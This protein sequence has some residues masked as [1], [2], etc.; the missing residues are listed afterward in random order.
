MPPWPDVDFKV[1]M[2]FTPIVEIFLFYAPR[3]LLNLEPF[4]F[5]FQELPES[6]AGLFFSS[7]F[8]KN[9]IDSGHWKD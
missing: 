9:I 1:P 5:N 7:I 4:P 8:M 3:H 2:S 6:K